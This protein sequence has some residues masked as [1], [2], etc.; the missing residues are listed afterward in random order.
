MPHSNEKLAENS[1][2][3]YVTDCAGRL[4]EG[5]KGHSGSNNLFNLVKN[6]LYT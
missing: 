6:P 2:E 1:N 3:N 4:Q 5:T